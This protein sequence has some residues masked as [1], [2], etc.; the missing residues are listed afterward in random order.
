MTRSPTHIIWYGS[1]AYVARANTGLQKLAT[2]GASVMVSDGDDGAQSSSPDGSDPIDPNRWCGGSEYA[3]YPKTSSKCAEILLT[4][5]TLS[6]PKSCPWPVGASGELCNFLYL[7]DFYQDAAIEKA[8][9]KANPSC[10]IQIFYDGS[11]GVHLYSECTCD[12]LSPLSHEGVVSQ[13]YKFNASARVFFADFPTGSPYVTSVG[14]TLFKSSDG[15]TVDAEHAASIIDGAIIT[16]GGGFSAVAPQ[17]AWQKSAVSAWHTGAPAAAKPPASMYDATMRGY[18][19]VTLN[20]HNYQVFYQGKTTTCAQGGV[21]GTSA[22]SPAFAGIV[23]LLNGALLAEGKSALGFLNPLLYKMAQE[24][25]AAFRDVTY[26]D[27]KCTRNF[28]MLY[29]YN[30]TQGWDPVAGLG[31]INYAAMKAYVLAQKGV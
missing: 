7:G 31:S 14:A 24:A 16:T 28:C 18:P 13:V 5:E 15:T 8:L 3:C 21:D 23:T 26:G 11:Y 19:D 27:N 1:K 29:G 2:L 4:N 6:P 12:Q 9:A 20:G 30:A 25:P 17:P 22:S 10:G